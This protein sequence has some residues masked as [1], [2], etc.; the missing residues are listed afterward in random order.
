MNLSYP[1]LAAL[2]LAVLVVVI[3]ATMHTASAAITPAQ[4][5]FE[6]FPGD[7]NLR[8]VRDRQGVIV[9]VTEPNGVHRD[10]T[11]EAKF[12]LDDPDESQSRERC[13]SAAR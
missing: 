4:A 6:V 3:G 11:A 8:T 13:A 5:T 10:V 7:V 9:R 2:R 12:T 1:F